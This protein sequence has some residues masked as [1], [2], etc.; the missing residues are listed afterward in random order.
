MFLL[1]NNIRREIKFKIFIKDLGKFYSWLYNSPFKRK[2]DNRGVNSLYYDTIN[3]DFANDNISGQS[4]RIKIRTRWYTENNEN[5]LNNFSNNDFFRFE[6]KRKKNN[7]S[8]KIL[9]SKKFSD[10]KRSIFEQRVF[11]KKELKNELSKFSELSHLIL[12]DIVFVSYNREY[13]EHTFSENIR[14]TI[15]KDLACLICSKIPNSKNTK[16]ANNFIIVELKFKQEN[17][18]LVKNILKNFP[19]RQIRSSK[20][21]YAISKYYRFSY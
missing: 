2:Y 18:S 9:F 16:I 21:L 1:N 17:E 7:Y 3:L 19:F 14:I 13:F 6:I 12:N 11:L 4:N 10:K 5:F 15:D 8:D 20:Y